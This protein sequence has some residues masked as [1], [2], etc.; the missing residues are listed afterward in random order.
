MIRVDQIS[1]TFGETKAVDKLSFTAK[2]G[3]ILALLGPNGAGKSTTMRMISGLMEPNQGSVHIDDFE[4][5]GQRKQATMRLGL[6]PDGAGLYPRLT[7]RE[8]IS[9]F[10]QLCGYT[11]ASAKE[12]TQAV[13]EDMHLHALADRQTQGFSQ[14]ERMKVAL[15]RAL[16]HEPQNLVLDEPTN[17]LDVMS[18]RAMRKRL[19]NLK[20][21][22]RCL[23]VSSHIM[24]EIAAISDRIV[25]IAR[26]K[27]V[28]Q[29]TLDALCDQAKSRDLEEAFVRLCGLQEE[30][31]DE[32]CEER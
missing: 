18:T 27:V 12:R 22:G 7:T 17:G 30:R 1:K 15:A 28:A 14:G 3:E 21:K 8:N 4:V 16:V 6:L 32:T 31:S 10:A 11:K 25:V 24:Q 5:R 26:G 2:D 19:M 29:G 23:I 9:Y 20:A 13:I